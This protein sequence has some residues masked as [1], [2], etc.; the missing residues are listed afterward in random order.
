MA[1]AD[2]YFAPCF[3]D[4]GREPGW[5]LIYPDLDAPD[6]ELYVGPFETF[7]AALQQSLAERV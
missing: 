2:L 7:D 6:D 5:Y 4:E 3:Q 1:E